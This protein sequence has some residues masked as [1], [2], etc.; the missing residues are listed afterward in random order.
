MDNIFTRL[1]SPGEFYFWF[2]ILIGLGLI[3]RW[4]WRRFFGA[5]TWDRQ[6]AF[7]EQISLTV[8]IVT[9]LVLSV[10]QIIL[11]NFF[12]TGLIWIEPMLRHLVL[13][14]C[15]VGAVTAAGRLRHIQMDVVGHLLP[16]SPRI[17]LVRFTTFVAA[18]ICAVLARASWTFMG[19]EFE[20]GA[21][22]FLDLPVWLLT[23]AI[24]LGFAL[25]ANRFIIR[26]FAPQKFLLKLVHIEQED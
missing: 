13:W 10:L 21:K 19:Q 3:K 14:I 17:L 8:L 7:L 11:R 16:D 12:H 20:F 22:G 5:E 26:A 18:L 2:A 4:L 24:F 6:I 9:M 1:D 23:S 15:F 25:M